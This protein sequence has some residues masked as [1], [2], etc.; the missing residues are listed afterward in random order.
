MFERAFPLVMALF[1]ASAGCGG[2]HETRYVVPGGD[3][4]PA[5]EEDGDSVVGDDDD[6]ADPWSLTEID[7]L[8]VP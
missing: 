3:P 6:V 5:A 4:T 2:T 1:L 8:S 7:V